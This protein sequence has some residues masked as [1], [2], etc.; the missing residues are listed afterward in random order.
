MSAPIAAAPKKRRHA[1][2]EVLPIPKLA[3]Y[4]FQHVV[5]FNGCTGT[6]LFGVGYLVRASFHRPS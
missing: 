1:I 3:T 2:D 4:G 5:A 6:G